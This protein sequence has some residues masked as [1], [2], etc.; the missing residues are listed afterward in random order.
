MSNYEKILEFFVN[1]NIILTEDQLKD[2]QDL[3]ADDI[4]NDSVESLEET[5][6]IKNSEYDNMSFGLYQASEGNNFYKS[7][8]IKVFIGSNPNTSPKIARINLKNLTYEHHNKDS[9]TQKSWE[10]S[11]KEKKNL[12]AIMAKNS[13][14]YK[15][16]TVW[17]ETIIVLS[18]ECKQP[19]SYYEKMFPDGCPDFTQ[20]K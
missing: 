16:K 7:P 19:I 11:S 10:L 12:N 14:K 5:T 13:K 8:Y 1:N 20:L 18:N 3:F 9:S 6:I 4:N 17:E 15:G 2:L